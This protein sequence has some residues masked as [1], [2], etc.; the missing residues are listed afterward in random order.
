M[1]FE[2]VYYQ[3]LG[4]LNHLISSLD[5]KDFLF[6]QLLHIPRTCEKRP[7]PLSC[8]NRAVFEHR[9]IPEGGIV[10]YPSLQGLGLNQSSCGK[11]GDFRKKTGTF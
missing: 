11:L 9:F 3:D 2:P 6:G 1:N 4:T 5:G 7:N 8:L 10:L